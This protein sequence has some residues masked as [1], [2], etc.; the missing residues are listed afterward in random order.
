MNDL[1]DFKTKLRQLMAEHEFEAAIQKLK[2]ALPEDGDMAN[3]VFL[4]EIRLEK[5]GRDSRAGVLNMEQETTATNKISQDLLGIIQTLKA[6][7]FEEIAA[8]NVSTKSTFEKLVDANGKV[9][10]ITSKVSLTSTLKK[11]RLEL[12]LKLLNQQIDRLIDDITIL[13]ESIG[14]EF[15]IIRKKQYQKR[16]NQKEEEIDKMIQTIENIESELTT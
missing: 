8:E 1:P 7:H 16:I 3:A 13:S 10:A 15:D 11:K 9:S 12:K 5:L 6:E 14:E 4:L 2:K